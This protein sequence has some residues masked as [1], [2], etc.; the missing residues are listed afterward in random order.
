MLRKD[1]LIG[2]A[3]L[4]AAASLLPAAA[5]IRTLVLTGQ[6]DAAHDWRAGAAM[7]ETIL[8][9]TGRFS[10][11]VNQEPRGLSQDTLAPYDLVVVHYNGPRWGPAAEKA[12]EQWLAS[13]KGLVSFHGVSY[14]PFMGTEQRPEGWIHRPETAW[15]AWPRLLGA[16]WA[17]DRIGHSIPHA[18]RVRVSDRS[19]PITRDMPPEFLV[20]DEL[21]HRMTLHPEARVLGVAFNDAAMKGTGQDEPVFWVA[22]WGRGR[23]FHTTLGHDAAAMHQPGFATLLARAAE[24]AATGSVTLAGWLR[25]QS[26]QGTPLRVLLVTGGHSYPTSL[27]TLLEGYEEITWSHAASSAEAY[28]ADLKERW[29]VL[30]LHDMRED[31]AAAERENLRAFVES[32]KGVVSIHHAIVNYTA[33]PWWHTE[34]IGG[35]YYTKPANGRPASTF[36]EGVKLVVRPVAEMRNHPLLRGVL[37][38][39]V[40]DEAYKGMWHSPRIQVVMETDHP[41]ND[42]PIVYL[43]PAAGSRAVY[44]QLGHSDSTI[45]HPGYRRLVRNAILWAGR[46]LR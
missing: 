44:I 17:P 39:I 7:L 1:T 10:V 38:L 20:S 8:A 9:A 33:W 15:P 5:P 36:K 11:R 42:R 13:G 25:A 19:H 40:E 43:G 24:W 45:R 6:S 35:K 14:G 16:F 4:I 18:F 30:V 26:R 12:V 31:L 32:G 29:D 37:P 28:R 46:R 3:G 27:Y 22:N 41:L 23:T 34:V 21:Y 2:F